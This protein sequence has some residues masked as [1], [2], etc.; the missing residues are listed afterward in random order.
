M[1]AA[2]A[3][4]IAGVATKDFC[5]HNDRDPTCLCFECREFAYAREVFDPGQT[6]TVVISS[7]L[8]T[9]EESKDHA[10]KATISSDMEDFS[11]QNNTVITRHSIGPLP[12]EPCEKGDEAGWPS[13]SG[14]LQMNT[15]Y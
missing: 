1:S 7:R 15:G 14:S 9:L 6:L 5:N 3:L 11:P 13:I 10:V 4:P 12:E 2:I 8:F